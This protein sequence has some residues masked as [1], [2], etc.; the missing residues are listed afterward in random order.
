MQIILV[1]YANHSSE[2][3]RQS[4]GITGFHGPENKY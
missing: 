2:V 4:I 3:Y 1:E